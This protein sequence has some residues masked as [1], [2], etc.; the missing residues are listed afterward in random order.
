MSITL[1]IYLDG[2]KVQDPRDWSEIKEFFAY[3]QNSNQ[4]SLAQESFEFVGDAAQ[5]LYSK[6]INGDILKKVTVDMVYKQNNSVV[7]LFQ[8]F[9]V[10]LT[11]EKLSIKREKFTQ[12]NIPISIEAPIKTNNGIDQFQKN[13][14]GLTWLLLDEEGYVNDSDYTT[15]KTII[16]KRYNPIDI[17]ISIVGLYVIFNQIQELIKDQREL[18]ENTVAHA[19]GGTTGTFAASVYFAVVTI[20][21]VI[22][23]IVLIASAIRIA[24]DLLFLLV[25]PIVKNKGITL[26]RGL[27][28]ICSYF[29]LN[30]VAT[31]PELDYETYLPSAPH[32]NDKNLLDGLLPKLVSTEK[33]YPNANDFGYNANEFFEIVKMRFNARIDII[34]DELFIRNEDD[35]VFFEQG[36]F[37]PKIDVDYETVVPNIS[38]IPKSRFISFL[39]DPS[40]DYTYENQ[41]GNKYEVINEVI[42]DDVIPFSGVEL[43]NLNVARG[44]PKTKLKPVE[45]FMK[46]LAGLVD[47]LVET[48]GGS[49]NLESQIEN[50]RVNVLQI[51]NQYWSVP[52]LVPVIGGQVPA[53]ALELVSAKSIENNYYINRSIVRG[54]GQKWIYPNVTIP[55]T[56]A[57]REQ[58]LQSGNFITPDGQNATLRELEWTISSDTASTTY[59]VKNDYIANNYFREVISEPS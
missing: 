14:D 41:L 12:R 9:Y 6:I 35:P 34:G 48:F 29:N 19:T 16:V 4:P 23:A 56:L 40:D 15:V 32:N 59:E 30:L 31:F 22:A 55:F 8:N 54:T 26:R 46:E 47:V 50:N 3:G 28:I 57:D 42:G 27:E 53:N 18:V 51:S 37:S 33:G 13:L 38:E 58:I 25:P 21:R 20:V 39:V 17:C 10:D 2:Q 44:T 7:N 5:Y 36:G 52:K 11:D 49:S 24:T 45:L 43:I 1:D